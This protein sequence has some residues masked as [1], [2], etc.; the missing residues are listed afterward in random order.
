MPVE[1]QVG[2]VMIRKDLLLPVGMDLVMES[3][4]ENWKSLALDAPGVQRAIQLSGWR[5]FFMAGEISA[6]AFGSG[7]P[8]NV[9]RAV[10]RI[11]NKVQH[12]D[13]NAI[14]VT[15]ISK[16]RLIGIP[17]IRIAAHS[18]HLQDGCVLASAEQRKRS[19]HAAD[20][21]RN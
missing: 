14:E 4:S 11:V 9:R 10:L 18:R 1:A 2:T 6:I 16:R 19:Q 13:F 17:Y 21:A 7:S 5:L 3:Y 12:T 15:K 8:K 20:W